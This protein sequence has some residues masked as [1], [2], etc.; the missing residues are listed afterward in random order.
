MNFSLRQLFILMLVLAL[1]IK[2]GLTGRNVNSLRQWVFIQQDRQRELEE[3]LAPDR[4]TIRICETLLK[5]REH[6]S[7]IEYPSNIKIIYPSKEAAAAY[8]RFQQRQPRG[9]DE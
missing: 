3:S 1:V 2:A 7:T 6:F 9:T 5:D 4:L 8:E